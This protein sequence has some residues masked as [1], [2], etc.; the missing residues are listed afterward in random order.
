[1]IRIF[2]EPPCPMRK[3]G[4]RFSRPQLQ[5]LRNQSVGKICKG[6]S[7][8][9]QF[10]AVTR[11]KMSSIEFFAYSIS[12]SKNPFSS[13]AVSQSSHSPSLFER[14]A[15]LSDQFFVRERRL[16]IAIGHPHEAVRGVLSMYQ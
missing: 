15:L 16:R 2:E 3:L 11:I 5:V 13:A 4:R 10:V 9:P 6:A 8:G 1:M 14:A 7:T 12:R